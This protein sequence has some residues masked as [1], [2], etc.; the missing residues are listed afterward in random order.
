MTTSEGKAN[1]RQNASHLHCSSA[2]DKVNMPKC[3]STLD[4]VKKSQ[5][6]RHID[7][8]KTTETQWFLSYGSC[9]VIK[10]LIIFTFYK[11]YLIAQKS[12]LGVIPYIF[13]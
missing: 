6:D 8:I 12:V 11:I 7:K 13:C 5:S 1:A 9:A 4:V 10:F 3:D 2:V